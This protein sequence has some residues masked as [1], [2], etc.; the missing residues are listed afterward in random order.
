MPTVEV[1]PDELRTLTGHDE[2]ADEELKDDLFALGLEFEVALLRLAL[3]LDAQREQIGREFVVA[4]L[5][6]AGQ[7][8]ELVGIEVDGGHQ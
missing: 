8:A 4:L 3:E 5:V 1:D 7:A 6:V 2:K